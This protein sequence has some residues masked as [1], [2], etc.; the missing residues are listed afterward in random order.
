[1]ERAAIKICTSTIL[2][3]RKPSIQA[4][5]QV[6]SYSCERYFLVPQQFQPGFYREVLRGAGGINSA[7]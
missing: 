7:D 6:H 3:R 1:M 4:V 5:P 2:K